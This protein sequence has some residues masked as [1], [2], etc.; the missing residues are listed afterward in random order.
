[1]SKSWVVVLLGTSQTLAWASSYYIP[2]I[3]AGAMAR[4]LGVEP[5]TVFVAFSCA[6]LFTAFL[7]PR[8]GRAIDQYGGRV[9]LLASNLIFIL[10]LAMLAMA[11]GPVMLF[12]AWLVLGLGMAMG[13][14][15]AGF[16]TLAGLYGKDARS[17]ITGITLIA[18]FASTI[19]W[20]ISGLMLSE[21]GWRGAC[22]G[23]ALVHLALAMPINLMLPRPTQRAAP[24][25]K[26]AAPPTAEAAKETRRTAILM[27]FVFAS[28]G[29]AAAALAAHL[30]ALLVS[31][32]ATPAAA[33]AAGALM[34]PAQV[35]A[36]VLEFTLLRR[37]H[38][39]LSAK[40]AQVTHPIGAG[41]L[42]LLGAP[43]APLFVLLHGAGN[44]INT[45]V[46]GTLPLAVFGAAGYGARQG[47]IVAPARFLGAVAPAL[48]G[49]VVAAFGV[50]ALWFTAGLSLLAFAALFML[51]VAPESPEARR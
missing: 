31:A 51:R 46:R 35:A 5:S 9:V 47:L 41:V 33:I 39:L 50:H 16:A 21:F 2:A 37:A 45:I 48:F 17:A 28:G 25:A 20:P 22:W 29:F 36:R 15:D 44:G 42:L 40:I 8:V 18:G 30:P 38:P 23:W 19:G 34:G 27:A 10:G 7:G 1:M 24:A 3:L 49:F 4:D 11:N 14:Y 12:A 13:L 32:G 26:P 6:M 43:F